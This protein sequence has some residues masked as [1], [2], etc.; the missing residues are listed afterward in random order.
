MRGIEQ[1]DLRHERSEVVVDQGQFVV[2]VAAHGRCWILCPS[3]SA[4]TLRTGPRATVRSTERRRAKVS[5]HGR[6]WILCPSATATEL[7]PLRGVKGNRG[8]AQSVAAVGSCVLQ[9]RATPLG[10]KRGRAGASIP[11]RCWILCPSAQPPSQPHARVM[12][13]S[14]MDGMQASQEKTSGK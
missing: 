1:R 6:C 11:G 9:Q 4:A 12:W 5:V 7:V 2:R 3:A 13:A 10:L 14:G 8:V